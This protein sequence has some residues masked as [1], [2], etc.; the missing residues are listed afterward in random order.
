MVHLSACCL[1]L[2]TQN[3]TLI[4][5][6]VSAVSM[7][8]QNGK[9]DQTASGWRLRVG[10]LIFVLSIIIPVIA[11]PAVMALEL[12]ASLTAS[13]S[14]GLLIGAELL[15]IAAVAVMGK[16]GFLFFKSRIS[17]FL[18]QYGPP[19][20]VSRRRYT[21]GL[22]MFSIP[23]LFALLSVYVH[24]YIPGYAANPIPYAISGDL[25]LLTSLFVLG[26][27]FWDK[28]RALFVYSDRVCR[29]NTTFDDQGRPS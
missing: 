24:E 8:E 12:S 19:Q 29:S 4:I 22:T 17:A 7:S 15:G 10:I 20:E 5:K 18:R 6:R 25:L 13:V 28:L 1:S 23:I 3:Q 2:Q 16:P 26:G 9:Q 11:V 14:G 27:D 21:I